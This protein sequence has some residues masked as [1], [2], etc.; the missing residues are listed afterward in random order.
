MKYHQTQ[1]FSKSSVTTP[2]TQNPQGVG[3]VGALKPSEGS[4]EGKEHRW[5]TN[6]CVT[7]GRGAK[8]HSLLYMQLKKEVSL[9]N[10]DEAMLMKW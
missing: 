6:C 2:H 1:Q 5:R 8:P 7:P 3:Q 10:V 4:C 9:K